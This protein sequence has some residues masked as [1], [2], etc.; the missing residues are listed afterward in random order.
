[1]KFIKIEIQT[2]HHLKGGFYFIKPLK[3]K[4][5]DVIPKQNSGF[6]VYIPQ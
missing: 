1:V 6:D 2:R 4:Y 3:N 5:I